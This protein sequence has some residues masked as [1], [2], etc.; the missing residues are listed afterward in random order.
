MV[1]MVSHRAVMIAAASFGMISYLDGNAGFSIICK[2]NWS[3]GTGRIAVLMVRRGARCGTGFL[4]V[5]APPASISWATPAAPESEQ[6]SARSR[7]AVNIGKKKNSCLAGIGG[8]FGMEAGLGDRA[9]GILQAHGKRIF[10]MRIHHLLREIGWT[11]PANRDPGLANHADDAD[12]RP[13]TLM[14]RGVIS[15]ITRPL[16]SRATTARLLA[17]AGSGLASCHGVKGGG[18]R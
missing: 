1:W 15:L 11:E 18:R 16:P 10:K 5:N 14:K 17:M 8:L 3:A 13:L 12:G 7:F 4:V 2:I 9:G 6:C